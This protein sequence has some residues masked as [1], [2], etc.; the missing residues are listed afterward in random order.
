MVSGAFV[1]RLVAQGGAERVGVGGGRGAGAGFPE[2]DALD[3]GIHAFGHRELVGSGAG[4]AAGQL[5]AGETEGLT[6]GADGVGG[7]WARHGRYLP[8]A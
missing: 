2:A 6:G 1:L 7:G 4:D 8:V 5:Q 3:D